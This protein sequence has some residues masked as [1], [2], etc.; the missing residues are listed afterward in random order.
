M[1]DSAS[2]R[3][4]SLSIEKIQPRIMVALFNGNPGTT[5]LCYNP[6]KASNKTDPDT[7]Y[8]LVRCVSKHDVPIKEGDLNAHL[9]KI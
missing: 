2:A 5:I 4:K 8:I 6:T 1:F 7:F 9:G 3:K